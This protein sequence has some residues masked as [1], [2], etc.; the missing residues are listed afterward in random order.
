MQTTTD[1]PRRNNNWS[2][3]LLL[4]PFIGTLYPPFYNSVSPSAGGLP[5]F[6]WYLLS[7]VVVTGVIMA[8]VYRLRRDRPA[9]AE[10]VAR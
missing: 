8:I 3:W 4:L 2:L 10:G 5:F 6:D 7:W 9:G 1:R